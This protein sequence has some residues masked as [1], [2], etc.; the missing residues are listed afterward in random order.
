MATKTP[1]IILVMADQLAPQ[2]LPSYGH[3]SDH[4]PTLHRLSE[5]GVT[6]DAA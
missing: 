3:P 5:E 4:A 6:F 1:N 2:F